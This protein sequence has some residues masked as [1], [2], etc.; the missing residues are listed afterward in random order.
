MRGTEKIYIHEKKII[1]LENQ[2]KPRTDYQSQSE[3]FTVLL[4]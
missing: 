2:R 1:N 4:I 3:H